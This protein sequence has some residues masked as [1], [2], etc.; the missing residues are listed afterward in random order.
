[1]DT[2]KRG[3]IAVSKKELF[4]LIKTIELTENNIDIIMH[5]KESFE[6]GKK[7]AKQINHLTNKRQAFQHFQLNIPVEKLK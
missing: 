2:L 3:Q 7:I 6:R 5:E 1:M 4:D